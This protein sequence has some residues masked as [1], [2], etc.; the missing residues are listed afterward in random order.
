MLAPF[1]WNNGAI[2]PCWPQ[3]CLW[4]ARGEARAGQGTL[5]QK[6]SITHQQE[7]Q[8]VSGTGKLNCSL[9]SLSL[10]IMPPGCSILGVE[11]C[12]APHN[13]FDSCQEGEW[14]LRLSRGDGGSGCPCAEELG[15]AKSPFPSCKGQPNM[16]ALQQGR[17]AELQKVTEHFPKF[18]L[19]CP[20]FWG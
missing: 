12:S 10:Q 8:T 11:T 6:E 17:W 5:A 16:G 4:G 18:S 15:A 1:L 19:Q 7:L 20:S 13:G 2:M 9:F 3:E 14:V